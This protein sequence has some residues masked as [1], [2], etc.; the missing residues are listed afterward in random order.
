MIPRTLVPTF[1]RPVDPSAEE[2]RRPRR[3]VTSLD[4]RLLV[5]GGLP[6]VELDTRSTIPTHV[7]LDVLGNRLVVPRDMPATPLETQ[8]A[9][10]THLPLTVLDSRVVVPKSARPLELKPGKP[11]RVTPDSAVLA[12]DVFTT[13]EVQ[14]LP[15]AVEEEATGWDPAGNWQAKVSSVLLHALL[16]LLVLLQPRLF[17]FQ[18]HTPEQ[19]E[20]ASRTLGMVYLPPGQPVTPPPAPPVVVPQPS[21]QIR[22]DPRVFQQISPE[23]E[24]APNVSEAPSREPM[25]ETP[26]RG[27]AQPE[28]PRLIEPVRP[29]QRP[30]PTLDPPKS[31][32]GSNPFALPGLSPGRALE[33]SLRSAAKSGSGG[34]TTGTFGG[35]IPSGPLGRGGGAGKAYGAIELLTPTEG[36]DFSNYLARVLASVRRNWYAVIPESARLGE[37]GKVV[38]QFRILRNGSVPPGEPNLVR[39]SG[40][41]PLDFAAMSSI[42]SSNPFEPLPGQFSGPFIELRFIYLYNL[43]LD[44]P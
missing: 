43:P 16:F 29:E 12:P 8:T 11:V 23:L 3:A 40:R 10:P 2:D 9:I 22:I 34:P 42:H 1:V 7:P 38:L 32:T 4:A 20:L 33:E 28:A 15:R 37:R 31:A 6:V 36:V 35:D 41:Q 17:P 30:A 24:T 13:G 19:N 39:T 18:P 27:E 26:R 44:T 25:T 14:L 21:P 5:P